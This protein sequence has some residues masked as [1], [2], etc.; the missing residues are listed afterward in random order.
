MS[1]RIP[2]DQL[3]V[4]H[5]HVSHHLKKVTSNDHKRLRRGPVYVEVD[6]RVLSPLLDE[7]KKR[8]AGPGRKGSFELGKTTKVLM[9]LKVGESVEIEPVIPS[10][11]ATSRRTARKYLGIDDAVWQAKTQDNGLLLITRMPDGSNPHAD[12][13]NPAVQQM[14]A[15]KV[16]E[17]VILTTLKSK[18]HNGIKIHAKKLMDNAEA[19]WQ[20]EN[21]ANGNVRC[22]RIR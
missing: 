10:T 21:L 9:S 14:A 20:C 19:K 2:D 15:M 1:R 17:T 11:L 18:I 22:R 7:L 4:M 3:E 16:G 12:Y 13:S 8:R 5:L 6:A